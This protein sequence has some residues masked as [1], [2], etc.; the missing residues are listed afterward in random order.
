M[1]R[2]ITSVTMLDKL[3]NGDAVEWQDFCENYKQYV[4]RRL[5]G[6][7][8]DSD[9]DDLLQRVMLKVHKYLPRFEHQ[10][11]GSFHGWLRRILNTELSDFLRERGRT[12]QLPEELAELANEDDVSRHWSRVHNNYVIRYL[13][14]RIRAEVSPQE[15][16]ILHLRYFNDCTYQQIAERV[17]KTAPAVVHIHARLMRRLREVGAGLLD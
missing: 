14:D 2:D 10:G 3:K 7:V 12:P 15:Y 13:L 1:K 16:E 4:D 17:G 5:R 8:P 6:L 9:R 11:K